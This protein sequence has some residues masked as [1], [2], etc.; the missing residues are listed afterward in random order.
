LQEVRPRDKIEEVAKT[1]VLALLVISSAAVAAADTPAPAPVLLSRQ[2]AERAHAAVGDVVTLAV[3]AHGSSGRTVRVVGI[4]EPT[5][6]PMRF[7]AERLEARMHLV[8]LIELM[9]GSDDPTARDSVDAINVRL[10]NPAGAD[11]FAKDVAA[12]MPGL[13]V[14][15]TSRP[16]EGDPFGALDRFHLAISIVTMAGSTAFLLALMVIRAEERRA[17]IG[18]MRLLGISRKTLLAEVAVEGLLI[19]ALGAVLGILLAIGAEG[20]VNRVFQSRY[21]TTLVFLRVT[22]SIAL[23]AIAV[24]VPL[25]VVAG[26]GASWAL[27]RRDI[28]SLVGR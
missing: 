4:Y 24:A 15:P 26:I 6:D 3:D 23:R 21:D 25:G 14:R 10:V 16:P 7:T 17:T 11:A 5:P 13:D 1:L 20:M 18:A 27:L 12:R 28:L 22:R 2:L 8:D 19:A 9:A